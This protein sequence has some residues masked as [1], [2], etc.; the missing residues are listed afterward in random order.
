MTGAKEK[1]KTGIP[2]VEAARHFNA[3]KGW[4]FAAQ[5]DLERGDRLDALDALEMA[6]RHLKESKKATYGS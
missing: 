5:N 6:V 2:A 4:V 1:R 3:A